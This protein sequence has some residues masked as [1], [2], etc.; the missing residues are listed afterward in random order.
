MAD[1]YI[2]ENGTLTPAFIYEGEKI[3]VEYPTGTKG[4]EKGIHFEVPPAK[5]HTMLRN[6]TLP[7]GEPC[8]VLLEKSPITRLPLVVLS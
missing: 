7:S 5:V 2:L 1:G 4:A 8:T 3:A 6:A